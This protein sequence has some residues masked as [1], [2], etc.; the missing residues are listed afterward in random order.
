MAGYKIIFNPEAGQA[1]AIKKLPALRKIL[2]VQK[3]EYEIELTEAPGHAVE[4]ARA[5][6]DGGYDCIVGA[7][8][9]GTANDVLNGL[10]LAK[11]SGIDIPALG[12][13]CVG[14]G[15]DFAFG[16]GIPADLEAGVD[17]L[18]KG[19]RR[20]MDVGLIKGGEYPDGRY[21]GN[22]IGI[23]FDTIVSFEAT[24]L[25]WVKGLA[26]YVIGAFKALLFYYKTPLLRI[27]NDGEAQLKA[28]LQISVMNGRRM[29]G[30]FYMTPQAEIDDGMFD[31]CTVG[32]P[33]RRNMLGIMLKYM[34]GTQDKSAD[35]IMGKTARFEVVAES[36]TLAVHADGETICT[37]GQMLDIECLPS[38]IEI[39]TREISPS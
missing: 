14:R 13:L 39:L 30:S 17:I 28:C 16:A 9:D 24:K 34:N 12:L 4:L 38:Q 37:A 21:F 7:G 1:S 3:I 11:K 15:N 35:V 33:K 6:A 32:T 25:K 36:G 10:M 29:G 18:Q 23:G 26:A 5:A 20:S 22:G 27:T 31:L 2:D 8:G 19:H